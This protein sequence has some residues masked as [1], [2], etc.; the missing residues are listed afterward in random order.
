MKALR[1]IHWET[2]PLALVPRHK[3]KPLH[4]GVT[5]H[6]NDDLAF[7]SN[8]VKI[9]FLNTDIQLARTFLDIALGARDAAK[10]ER[11]IRQARKAY[12][13]VQRGMSLVTLT[14]SEAQFLYQNLKLL[15]SA[16]ANLG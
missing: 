4:V 11:N 10:K 8:R 14:D 15:K 12:D 2:V 13:V 1:A 6:A 16:F 3:R 7:W 9:D 5:A